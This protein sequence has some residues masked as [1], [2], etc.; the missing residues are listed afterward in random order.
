MVFLL[1]LIMCVYVGANV[2][3][4]LR[5]VQSLPAMP[6]AARIGLGV[7]VAFMATAMFLALGLRNA[8]IPGAIHKILFT[9]GSLWL[10]FMLYMTL[11]LV[12]ADVVHHFV[13]AFV[14][15]VWYVLGITLLVMLYGYVNYRN[16]RVEHIEI[17][18]PKYRGEPLRLVVVSDVHLGYGT[19]RDRLA[20]YVDMINA[21]HPD[22]VL[23]A[24]DLIDNSLVPVRRAAMHE[25]LARIDAPQGVYM[26]LG[27][28]EYISGVEASRSFLADTP[29]T[30]LVD[31]VATLDCGV[32]IV[33]RDD[34][35]NK[36]RKSLEELLQCVDNEHVVIV[37]DHQP[38]DI[39]ESNR[40][41]V[42]IHLS[43]HTH[44]GQVWPLTW[45]TD[46]MYDQ[47]HGYRKWSTTHAI[48]SQGLSL[49]G[50]PFRVGSHSD[51]FVISILPAEK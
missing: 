10:V 30:L 40:T 27:N 19:N 14:G 42:D 49:W 15:R 28:H 35:T 2:Y 3:L 41:G 38:Y 48:V 4:Y 50:P 47:S 17:I 34:R 12:V 13:P 22:A 33:G 36:H 29:I 23:V 32:Q 24:G 18:S 11:G 16:P 7:A 8:D 39:A 20:R 25:E 44:R 46:A 45:F 9:L 6:L 51:M 5:L 43:G 31:S 21:E 37:L 26:S 1:I